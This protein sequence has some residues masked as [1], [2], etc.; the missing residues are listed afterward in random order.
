MLPVNLDALK[1]GGLYANIH[2][3]DNPSGEIRGQI[4]A[5]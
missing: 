1:S 4:V 2:S 5:Q 3:A